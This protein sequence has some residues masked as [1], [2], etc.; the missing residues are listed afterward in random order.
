MLATL[1]AELDD[2][3]ESGAA[4]DDLGAASDEIRRV[5]N[6]WRTRGRLADGRGRPFAASAQV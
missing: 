6:M 4:D 5:L 2:V 3:A 1:A